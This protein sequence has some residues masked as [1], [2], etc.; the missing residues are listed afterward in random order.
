LGAEPDTEKERFNHAYWVGLVGN[1]INIVWQIDQVKCF[2]SPLVS[3]ESGNIRGRDT[4]RI[5]DCGVVAFI[6]KLDV[7]VPGAKLPAFLHSSGCDSPP[8]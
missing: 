1:R 4:P 5:G 2:C 6:L 7:S 3:R 8:Q